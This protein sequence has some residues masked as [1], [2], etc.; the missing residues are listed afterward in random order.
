MAVSNRVWL[1]FFFIFILRL[2]TENGVLRFPQ[3]S[4][5]SSCLLLKQIV[6]AEATDR[7]ISSIL[8]CDRPVDTG[9]HFKK[10]SFN[11]ISP[12]SVP[13]GKIQTRKTPYL[14]TLHVVYKTHF[15]WKARAMLFKYSL[16]W[17]RV[18]NG[19]WEKAIL[20]KEEKKNSKN[21][22]GWINFHRNYIFYFVLLP[23]TRRNS[24]EKPVK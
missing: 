23:Q 12:Y 16:N 15:T 17:T 18:S 4:W 10:P 20:E 22:L 1:I 2:W 21:Y 19:S 11:R 3:I 9:F 6:I 7:A 13:L 8:Y 5:Y 14:D 24:S